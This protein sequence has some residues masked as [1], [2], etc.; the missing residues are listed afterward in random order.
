[1]KGKGEDKRG[2]RKG[3]E[4]GKTEME[5]V[6]ISKIRWLLGHTGVQYF[7][8]LVVLVLECMEFNI[9]KFSLAS[10]SASDI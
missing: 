10:T 2:K 6:N 4:K 9:S 7:E 5:R 3:K 1:M 8:G